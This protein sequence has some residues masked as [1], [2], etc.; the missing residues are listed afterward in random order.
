M[1]L[2]IFLLLIVFCSNNLKAEELNIWNIVKNDKYSGR[3]HDYIKTLE[4]K[5]IKYI[6][7]QKERNKEI[8][9]FI[10]KMLLRVSAINNKLDVVKTIVEAGG[11]V[12]YQDDIML[13]PLIL[14]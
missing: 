5:D 14:V 6:L 10:N 3:V 11:D 13:S 2:F 1:R 8:S 9:N 4:A 7:K 12:N